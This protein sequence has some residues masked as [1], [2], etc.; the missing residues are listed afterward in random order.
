MQDKSIK[1]VYRSYFHFN[2]ERTLSTDAA[3]ALWSSEAKGFSVFVDKTRKYD[4]QIILH[5]VCS[6]ANLD[7]H[8]TLYQHGFSPEI[9]IEPQAKTNELIAWL[10]RHEFVPGYEHEFLQL[11]SADYAAPADVSGHVAVER[12]THEQ[13]DEFLA[14]LKT[15]GLEC[16][17]SIWEKKRSLYCTETFRA[18]VAK[19]DG[20]P[21]A[22][23]TSFIENEYAILAN[24]YTQERYRSK[25]CQTALLRARIEDALSLGVQV[26]L[27]DVMTNTT[28]SKNCKSVGF[29]VIGVRSVWYKN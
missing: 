4:N 5:G 7:S 2:N 18:Y 22:W 1:D 29:S 17:D 10:S 14:L 11:R 20:E 9:A 12:W 16:S 13:V 26:V 23:A 8:L 15:S 28:S 3:S 24:A 21:C 19:I 6:T 27:T 25:G